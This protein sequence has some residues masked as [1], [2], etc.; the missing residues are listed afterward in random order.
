[1]SSGDQSPEERIAYLKS[2]SP[3]TAEAFRELALDFDVS[4]DYSP[5]S[6]NEVERLITENF[7]DRRGRVKK[8]HHDL[9]GATGAYVTEV[10]LRNLGGE[11][12][13]EPEWHIGGIRLPPARSPHPWQ[14]R[15]SGTKTVQATTS[16]RTTTS[17]LR[18]RR[19]E[20][21]SDPYG[22]HLPENTGAS[23]SH[24]PRR[25]CSF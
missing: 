16:S 18:R 24:R 13:W 1:M 11:W 14:N 25:G 6:V 21:P 9:A 4:L 20:R 17:W 19:D 12:D 15:A 10:I 2:W 7:T 3:E 8:K 22:L 5:E 23:G